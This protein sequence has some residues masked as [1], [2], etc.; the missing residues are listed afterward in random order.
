MEEHGRDAIL[1]RGE[2]RN[3]CFFQFLRLLFFHDDNPHRGGYLAE[4]T[5]DKSSNEKSS[6]VEDINRCLSASLQRV[7]KKQNKKSLLRS[8]GK[9]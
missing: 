9:I 3:A 2:K 6:V 1:A 8:D 5:V 7:N 4:N